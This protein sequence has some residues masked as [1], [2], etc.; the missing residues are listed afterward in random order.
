M[1]GMVR[2]LERLAFET[3]F[4]N[5][6]GFLMDIKSCEREFHGLMTRDEAGE[7]CEGWPCFS[8]DMFCECGN[9]GQDGEVVSMD[10][11]RQL[12]FCCLQETGWRGEGARRM[13]EFKF[14]WMGCE[15][16]IH[17]VGL[18][19]AD[20]WIEKV[21]DVSERFMVMRVI[22]GKTVLNSRHNIREDYYYLLLFVY[23]TSD[24]TLM[25]YNRICYN[26]RIQINK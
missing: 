4:L 7:G 2:N 19:V 18:L 12:G 3:C 15:R 1:N 8:E 6:L 24:K 23:S 20:K 25:P 21:L 17:G 22:V 26:T 13:V 5:N 16:G 11:G 9:E 10:T 14:F